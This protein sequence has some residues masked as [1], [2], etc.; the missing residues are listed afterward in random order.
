MPALGLLRAGNFCKSLN[1]KMTTNNKIIKIIIAT[2]KKYQMPKDE[3]YL[4]LQ[5]GAKGK[6]SLGYMRDDIGEN[7]SSYNSFYCEMTGLYWAWKNLEYDYLG[8]AHY[9]RLFCLYKKKDKWD[10]VLT[11]EQIFELCDKYDIIL[12]SK[13]HYFIE[14]IYSHYAHTHYSEHLD[15]TRDVL[16]EMYPEY[17][18]YYDRTL[19]RR[20]AYMFNMFIMRKDLVDEYSSFIFSVLEE[21]KN[22]VDYTG[23]TS[24][25]KRFV[26]RISEIVFN[27]W[28]EKKKQ[29][30]KTL[31]IKK[32]NC[33]YMDNIDWIKKGRAFLEAKFLGKK[34][35]T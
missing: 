24:F 12:P 31:R 34:Y 25:Q 21:V 14:T 18:P 15:V 27:A 26:G 5:V 20:S 28:L 32:I 16:T 30:D 6:K 2:H 1:S 29:D 17:V 19:S 9:R 35:L 23:Y 13:R 3:I 7:I 10:S 4:P 22:R 8:V 11:N 33:V